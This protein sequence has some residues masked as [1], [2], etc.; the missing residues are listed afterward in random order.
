MR[1][2][3][4]AT[5]I[6]LGSVLGA[7][8]ACTNDALVGSPGD[9]GADGGA[10]ADA[11][12]VTWMTSRAAF[13]SRFCDGS[14]QRLCTGWLRCC[15][16]IP[17]TDEAQCAAERAS[18]DC[19]AFVDSLA[20]LDDGRL[21][22]DGSALSRLLDQRVFTPECEFDPGLVTGHHVLHGDLPVGAACEGTSEDP[23]GL[24]ACE[25]GLV[26]RRGRAEPD[27]RVRGV[28]EMPGTLGAPC[29]PDARWYDVI[30]SRGCATSLRCATDGTCQPLV[31]LGGECDRGSDCES[32]N[33]RYEDGRGACAPVPPVVS[34][35]PRCAIIVDRRPGGCSV[36]FRGCPGSAETFYRVE[37]VDSECRCER[38]GL[39]S[40]VGAEIPDLCATEVPRDDLVAGA[41]DGCG[42]PLY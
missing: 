19:G 33:C 37:C 38:N 11:D 29:D 1:S 32:S 35:C 9:V 13:R 34:A 17:Y 12:G 18:T 30:L 25:L 20:G 7:L 2:N 8:N 27:G 28:C 24:F 21:Q 4:L 6:L 39:T 41:R 3:R 40:R 36:T 26:C 10:P 16:G 14:T 42:F 31:P 5:I 22:I 23:S 15:G